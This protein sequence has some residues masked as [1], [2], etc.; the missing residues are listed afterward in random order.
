MHDPRINVHRIPLPKGAKRPLETDKQQSDA[1]VFEKPDKKKLKVKKT[2]QLP[3]SLKG[4]KTKNQ[5][6][7]PLCWHFN[8]EKRCSNPVKSGRC[9]F[10]YH[11]F[12][13]CLKTG[14]G[15]HECKSHDNWLSADVE[16]SKTP[17]E[18]TLHCEFVNPS[19]PNTEPLGKEQSTEGDKNCPTKGLI[20]ETFRERVALVWPVVRPVFVPYQLT[21]TKKRS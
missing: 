15:A 8:L 4:T 5:Q 20:L 14:H 16:H 18:S 21:K 12:M 3:P 10:G 2:P 1:E 9:R 7:K 11:Q 17:M 6:G 19:H 13:R